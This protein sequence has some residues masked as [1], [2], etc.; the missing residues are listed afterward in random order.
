MALRRT[1]RVGLRWRSTNAGPPFLG[2]RR[3]VIG[4]DQ[5]EVRQPDRGAKGRGS[6]QKTARICS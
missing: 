4:L 5:P 2:V 6:D 3:P 1:V